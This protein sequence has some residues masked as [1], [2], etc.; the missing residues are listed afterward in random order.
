[1][2]KKEQDGYVQNALELLNTPIWIW[3]L[4][5]EKIIW[6]NPSAIALW[7][8]G[9]LEQLLQMDFSNEPLNDKFRK[10]AERFRYGETV[11]EEQIFSIS[12]QAST[13]TCQC[14]GIEIPDFELAALVEVRQISKG[15]MDIN[16]QSSIEALQH[17]PAMVSLHHLDGLGIM[18][19]PAAM[20]CFGYLDPGNPCNLH[21]RISD[22]KVTKSLFDS[23]EKG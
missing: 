15:S 4:V 22:P 2:T 20:R 6:A 13:V 8:A 3:D 18:R 5:T 7:G 1:M 19:N 12:G 16:I 17:T 23:L 21:D 10:M 9:N 11:E 14:Q